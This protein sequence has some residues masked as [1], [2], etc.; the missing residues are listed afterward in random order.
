VPMTQRSVVT[1][2]DALAISAQVQRAPSR[3]GRQRGWTYIG[4]GSHVKADPSRSAGCPDAGGRAASRAKWT[5]PIAYYLKHRYYPRNR[6]TAVTKAG[7]AACPR[8]MD[9]PARDDSVRE[10][11]PTTGLSTSADTAPLAS[12]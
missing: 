4:T 3:R 9:M 1:L 2:R 11:I 7:A 5:C 6:V 10:Q 8:G 12:D